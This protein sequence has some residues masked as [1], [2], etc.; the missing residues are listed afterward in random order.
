M[1]PDIKERNSKRWQDMETDVYDVSRMAQATALILDL[2]MEEK[3]DSAS[4]GVYTDR[5]LVKHLAPWS[6]AVDFM[7]HHLASMALDLRKHYA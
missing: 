7:V 6:D 4:G 1:T 5:E 3:K 2:Y